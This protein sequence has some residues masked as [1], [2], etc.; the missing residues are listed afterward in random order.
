[1]HIDLRP[2]WLHSAIFKNLISY[3]TME[4]AI[5]DTQYKGIEEKRNSGSPV[6]QRCQVRIIYLQREATY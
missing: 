4:L 1:M 3:G 2:G 5:L 6:E